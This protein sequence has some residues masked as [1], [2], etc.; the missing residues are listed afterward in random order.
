MMVDQMGSG[1]ASCSTR[2][3]MLII[4]S[5]RKHT[6]SWQTDRSRSGLKKKRAP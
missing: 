4:C 2:R 1:R 5:S 3:Q 6:F